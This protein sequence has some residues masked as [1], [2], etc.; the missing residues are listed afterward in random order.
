MG[1]TDGRVRF[2]ISFFRAFLTHCI[3]Y[4]AGVCLIEYFHVPATIIMNKARLRVR[5]ESH[6]MISSLYTDGE[7]NSTTQTTI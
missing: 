3:S 7:M 6:A 5:L 1:F 2:R 4:I